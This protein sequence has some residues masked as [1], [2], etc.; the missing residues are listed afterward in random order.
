MNYKYIYTIILVLFSINLMAQHK[1][2]NDTNH[3]SK[4]HKEHKH[5]KND[6]GIA[7]NAIYLFGE[8]EFVYGL[9]AHYIRTIKDGPFGIGVGYERIFGE[10]AHQTIGII[11]RYKPTENW[12]INLSPGIS[13]EEDET[14]FGVHLETAYLFDVGI[15]HMGPVLSVSTD[16]EEAHGGIGLHIG[17]GF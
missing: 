2:D 14:N 5:H 15:F 3:K 16:M 1:H 7:N 4:S 13:F 12:L 8:N 11:G 17:F 9:D 6:I 10:H